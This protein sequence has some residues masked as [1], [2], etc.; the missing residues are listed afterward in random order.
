MYCR[1]FRRSGRSPSSPAARCTISTN[2]KSGNLFRVGILL[3]FVWLTTRTPHGAYVRRARR[4]RIDPHGGEIERLR[5]DLHDVTALLGGA[6]AT[7][8]DSATT[9]GA[10]PQRHAVALTL[11]NGW[12]SQPTVDLGPRM[13]LVYIAVDYAHAHAP[14]TVTV[15]SDAT[16]Q[17]ADGPTILADI[18]LGATYAITK[19]SGNMFRVGIF[20]DFVWLTTRTPHGEYVWRARRN[21]IDPHGGVIER[22]RYDAR[23]ETH[24]WSQTG[25]EHATAPGRWTPAAVLPSP[26]L[27]G[28]VGVL[29]A[30]IMPRIRRCETFQPISAK[31]FPKTAA[32]AAVWVVD[33][34]PYLRCCAPRARALGS[35]QTCHG[36]VV[37]CSAVL[38]VILGAFVFVL[39]LATSF[40][41]FPLVRR[42]YL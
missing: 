27:P 11:G 14:G 24:G 28:G 17:A 39:V 26:L 36:A 16:W 9:S 20:L 1:P 19:R 34:G 21:R 29:R 10:A 3:D 8:S 2:K 35:C 23:R 33:F 42:R 37:L 18:Y 5:Y 41:P 31:W 22:L 25:Y 6:N 15:V 12:Y 40:C 7:D 32:A 13:A 30:Q 4:D 38:C